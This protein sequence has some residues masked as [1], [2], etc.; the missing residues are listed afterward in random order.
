VTPASHQPAS[1]AGELLV[2]FR[3]GTTEQ[4]K[5]AV[6]GSRGGRRGRR[7]R[8]DSAVEKIDLTGGQT[9]EGAASELRSRPEV[10]F[11]EPNFVINGEQTAANDPRVSEQ[12]ALRNT[13][14]GGGRQGSDIAA[15]AAWAKT[16]GSTQTVIAVI[17][18]G[19]DFTHPDLKNNEW[20]NAR[21]RVNNRDDDNDGFADDLHG[22]DWVADGNQILDQNGHGTAVAGVIAAEGNNGVGVAGVMWRASLMSLR[23]LDN[24]GAGDVASAVEAIDY[25]V[26]HGAQVVNLSWGTDG[27]SLALRDAIGRANA[28]GVVVVC[29]AGNGGRNVDG[30]PYY[31]TSYNLPNMISVAAADNTDLMTTWSNWGAQNVAVAAPGNNILTT[32]VGGDY[33]AVS[34]TSAAAPAVS[35]IVGLVRTLRPDLSASGVKSSIVDGA[36]RVAGLSGV[37]ASG[38]VASAAGALTAAAGLPPGGNGNGQG[39]GGANGNGDGQGSGGGNNGDGT[40]N[41]QGHGGD[42][43][44]PPAQRGSGGRGPGGSFDSAPPPVTKQ[45]PPGLGDQDEL[46]RRR[47]VDPKAPTFIHADVVLPVCDADCG[48]EVPAGAGGGDPYFAT[49]RTRPQNR[50]GGATTRT[51]SVGAG[52]DTGSM[53]INWGLPLVQLAGRAGLDLGIGL[54]YNSLVW[55]RQGDAM[56]FNADHGFPGPG[57]RLGFPALQ[58]RSYDTDEQAYTFVMVTPSGGRVQ[59]RQ[60]GATNAYES[61]DGGYVHLIDYNNGVGTALVRT[62]DGT[63]LT[64]V[65]YSSLNEFR[66]TKIEDRNGNYITVNYGAINGDASLGRPTSVVDTLGRQIDFNY[67][68]LSYLVSITQPWRRDTTSGAVTETHQ[69]A[70]FDYDALTVQ[71]NFPGLGVYG[72]GSDPIPVLKHVGLPDGTAYAFDYNS[73]GQ[74]YRIK[75]VAP[76]GRTLAQSTY[77]LPLDASAAQ[78]DCPRFTQRRDWA[79]F[80]NGDNGNQSVDAGEEAVTDFAVTKNTSWTM[81]DNTS[82]AGT[83]AQVSSPVYLDKDGAHRRIVQNS[84]S[85]ATGWDAGLPVL[86][87][88]FDRNEDANASTLKRWVTTS[89]TQDNTSLSIPQNP[90]VTETNVYDP[91]GNQGRTIVGYVTVSGITLPSAVEE[92]GKVNGVLTLLRRATTDY[93]WDSDYVNRRIIGLVGA[94]RVYDGA[95]ATVSKVEYHY[96]WVSGYMETNAP[97][98]QHDTT[99]YGSGFG[100]GRGIVTGVLR[101]NADA[102]DDANQGAWVLAKGYDLAGSTVWTSDANNHTTRIAY[103]DSFSNGVNTH[104]TRA[105]PT[106]VTDADNYQSTVKYNFDLGAAYRAQDPKGAASLTYYDAAGRVARVVNEVSGAYTTYGYDTNWGYNVTGSSVEAGQAEAYTNSITDGAG[107]VRVFVAGHPNSL[108]GY[109]STWVKYDA[110]GRAVEQ[111]NPTETDPGG[112]PWGDDA[113]GFVWSK[114]AYDWKGRLTL[115]TFPAV[116]GQTLGNT[117][118]FSYGGCGCAGGEVTTVRDERGRRRRLSMDALGR[119]ARVEEMNWDGTSVYSTTGY[120]YNARNQVTGVNQAGQT[121]SMDYD[122]FGRLWRRTTPE[123]GMT[124]YSYYADDTVQMVTDARGAT[125]TFGYNNRH[126]PTQISYGA[127]SGVAATGNVTM[128]YDAAGNRTSMADGLGSVS[129][130]YDTLSRL[131]SETRTFSGMGSYALSYEYNL[132][133]E[134]KRATNP[135]NA[136]VSYLYDAE[137]R[138]SDVKGSDAGGN[139]TYAGVS[140]YAQTLRYRA[141]DGLKGM[142]YGNGKTL[143]VGYDQRLRPV[144]WDVQG[145]LGSNY[146]YDKLNE[147]TGRVTFAQS[148]YDATLDRSYEYDQVGRLVR[149][150]SGNEADGH[151]GLTAWPSSPNGPYSHNYGYDAWGNMTQRVGWGG[152]NGGYTNATQAF[153]GNRQATNPWSGAALQYDAAGNLTY[154]GQ[155]YTFDATG[156][157]VSATGGAAA[158]SMAYDG[159]GLRAKKVDGGVTTYYLRSSVLGAKV[160]TEMNSSGGWVR[161]YVYSGS[162]LLAIQYAGAASWVHQDPVTKS[163]RVTSAAGAVTAGVELDP[164]GGETDRSFNSAFQPK[165]FTTYERDANSGDDAMMRR[166]QSYW[167]RFSQPDPSDGSYDLADPQSLNRYS[168]TQ[169]DPVNSTDPS[170]LE[171]IDGDGVDDGEADYEVYT[172]GAPWRG[173]FGGG[174]SSTAIAIEMP[175]GG[176]GGGIGGGTPGT[177]NRAPVSRPKPPCH[178]PDSGAGDIN[179]TWAPL[180]LGYTGGVQLTANKVHPYAGMAIGTSGASIMVQKKANISPGLNYSI[181][182]GFII[183][184]SWSGKLDP[185]NLRTIWSSLKNGSLMYGGTTPG[186]GGAITYVHRGWQIPCL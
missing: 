5:D 164:W 65:Y 52:E 106:T 8:G 50:T 17:D 45:V 149:A 22:W 57:F 178:G 177:Q 75:R 32:R 87:Q 46:R 61:A 117:R 176:E 94:R 186:I 77:N 44:P 127:A 67:D 19:I 88:T 147:N 167:M 9:P 93:K 56:M 153:S 85:H 12:W 142:T 73:W 76:N 36:R 133:G 24:T 126:L 84:Y 141:S 124:T 27:E 14:Q 103:S 7:L 179:G 41:G 121:R 112:T 180:G 168:Y 49:A 53:N 173:M 154:D 11:V 101:Y 113:A 118:E 96:D 148:L 47:W 79:D 163:Q 159:D 15:P 125:T 143:S 137:G 99:N 66:C 74:V 54:Y 108:G 146:S 42:T 131:S 48:N 95:G 144:Q 20:A 123:Q 13:G 119:L 152:V 62:T 157:Q 171:D 182:G 10:E 18:S 33:A 34:G 63:Q 161:G 25:A 136:Q 82:H 39:N 64:F 183:G 3:A 97:S 145:V 184:G 174:S 138:L 71:S 181:S 21:E 170:G 109:R 92:Y 55:T 70:T 30:T 51:S 72:P 28:A 83:L 130:V 58:A 40:G 1:R 104:N 29:S 23:V 120:S 139:P 160:V 135:W 4:E 102:P 151:V 115:A 162:Q 69:W 91:E 80:S 98:V 107:Q 6:V 31:P 86:E 169:N 38:G 105:Y 175:T 185:T 26:A 155:T 165:K 122:G 129:Y 100:Y 68:T 132:G 150:H 116:A 166:Y 60:V 37:V 43:P 110:L 114:Q 78:S 35:G 2:R 111:S 128:G 90:R 158:V 81:P 156:Q 59:M 134:L 89:W 16:T 172:R 140:T